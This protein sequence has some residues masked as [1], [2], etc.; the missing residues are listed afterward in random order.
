ML[1]MCPFRYFD[2]FSFNLETRVIFD[3]Y[4]RAFSDFQVKLFFD[5]GTKSLKRFT[6][7]LHNG[8]DG[9]LWLF[10]GVYGV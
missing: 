3:F 1:D 9:S 4:S 8:H 7:E 2:R 10:Y 6:F 5:F